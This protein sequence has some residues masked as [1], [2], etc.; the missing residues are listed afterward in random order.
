MNPPGAGISTSVMLLT[1]VVELVN[2]IVPEPAVPVWKP[3]D[4]CVTLFVTPAVSEKEGLVAYA[5]TTGVDPFMLIV[6]V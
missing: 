4:A 5:G 2:A 3:A 6:W 1:L